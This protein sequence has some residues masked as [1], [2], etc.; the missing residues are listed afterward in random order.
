MAYVRVEKSAAYAARY[1][2]VAD[3]C[4]ERTQR[5]RCVALLRRDAAVMIC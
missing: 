1:G 3:E 5:R 2:A 4:C